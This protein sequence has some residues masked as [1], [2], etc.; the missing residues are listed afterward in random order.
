MAASVLAP[1][2]KGTL[3]LSTL[4]RGVKPDFLVLFS[5]IISI[6]PPAGQVDYCGANAFLD[7]FAHCN[8]STNGT[9]VVSVNWDTWQETGMAVDTVVPLPFKMQ[10]E[11]TLKKGILSREGIDAF[12]RILGRRIPQLVVVTTNLQTLIDQRITPESLTEVVQSEA[13]STLLHS[14]PNLPNNYVPPKTEIQ[15]TIASIWQKLLGIEQI[16][17]YDNFFDLGGHSL[18]ATQVI[19]RVRDALQVELPPRA[20]FES[21]TLAGLAESVETIQWAGRGVKAHTGSTAGTHEEGTI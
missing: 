19:S 2:V 9:S 15:K 12:K 11:E 18:L 13:Q 1:K 5:S 20:I 3:N 10:R 8:Y 7:A 21:P 17:I 14:R 16:G 4:L 6:L